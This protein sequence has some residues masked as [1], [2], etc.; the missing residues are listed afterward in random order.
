MKLGKNK[1]KRADS[2]DKP[3]PPPLFMS[4]AL[5]TPLF[6]TATLSPS[7]SLTSPS[8]NFGCRYH[9]KKNSLFPSPPPSQNNFTWHLARLTIQVAPL[10]LQ[11]HSQPCPSIPVWPSPRSSMHLTVPPARLSNT[12]VFNWFLLFQNGRPD[13]VFVFNPS[14]PNW[15]RLARK[16]ETTRF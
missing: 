6:T 1:I 14:D 5:S 13:T 10:R 4:T 2:G 15:C 11:G 16:P 9:H 7:V 8:I 12:T 3:R